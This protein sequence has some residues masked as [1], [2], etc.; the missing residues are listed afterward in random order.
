MRAASIVFGSALILALAGCTV[1]GGP[2]PLAEETE[3][4]RIDFSRTTGFDGD[5]LTVFVK[6]KEKDGR[7][8]HLNTVRDAVETNAFRPQIPNHSARSWV[9]RNT[10]HD[11]TSRVYAIVSWNND[12][13]TDYIAAGW[14]RHDQQGAELP[15]WAVFVD[16]P[17]FDSTAN[18]PEMP[19]TGTARYRG[20][21]SGLFAYVFGSDW[22]ELGGRYTY[23]GYRG[24]M[25]VVADFEEGTLSGCFGCT[26]DL[27]AYRT[28]LDHSFRE[29]PEEYQPGV[30][31][32][33]KDYEI[34][35][36]PVAYS[37][38]G[39]FESASD[40][41]AGSVRHPERGVT[42]SR[43]FWGG[44][45]SNVHDEDGNPRLITGFKDAGFREEDGSR[46]VF[47][48]IFTVLSDTFRTEGQS[49]DGPEE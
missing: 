6:Q 5:K 32:P 38:L 46:G 25:D 10:A 14:W 41:A 31:I 8:L 42:G 48:G 15:E 44:S 29:I 24:N 39:N 2:D 26:G 16:G 37:D 34:H 47:W 18:P 1:G 30:D 13:P 3:E 11:S 17:E 28:H 21:G 43:V 19:V 35:F 4:G 7:Q 40:S 33:V 20:R 49:P 23:D 12:D 36:E 9:L 22:G 27:E 45:V